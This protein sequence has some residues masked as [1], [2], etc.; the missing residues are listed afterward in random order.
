MRAMR[1]TN[2]IRQPIPGSPRREAARRGSLLPAYRSASQLRRVRRPIR[3]S[4]CCGSM[5]RPA[6]GANFRYSAVAPPTGSACAS[7]RWATGTGLSDPHPYES[8]ADWA[9]DVAH[10]ADALGAERFGSSASPAAVRTRWPAPRRPPRR[11]RR[12]RGCPR[13]RRP[14]RRPGC[15]RDRRDRLARRFAP[16]LSGLRC[17]L[18]GAVSVPMRLSS[19][20]RTTPVRPMP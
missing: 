7:S 9:T 10:V 19:G 8:V 14:L 4:P 12:G 3:E 16:L 2:P 17:P 5:A 1:T 11:P 13:R 15:A 6:G 18:A 20:S